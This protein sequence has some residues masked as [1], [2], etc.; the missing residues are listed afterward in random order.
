MKRTH[1]V[2][3]RCDARCTRCAYLPHSLAATAP[4]QASA[5]MRT[6]AKA[7]WPLQG[8]GGEGAARRTGHGDGLGHAM[9]L[10]RR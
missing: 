5:L 8:M 4:T 9:E 1:A 2:R 7:H 3:T 6:G 10:R